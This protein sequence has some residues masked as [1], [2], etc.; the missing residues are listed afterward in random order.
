MK[1]PRDGTP[2]ETPVDRKGFLMTPGKPTEQI[3]LRDNKRI[4]F[5]DQQ[6]KS[7][8]DHGN[9]HEFITTDHTKMLLLTFH[10]RGSE[11]D[12]MPHLF[13]CFV[14]GVYRMQNWKQVVFF[15]EEFNDQSTEEPLRLDLH[16][17][18]S[19]FQVENVYLWFH[20][21]RPPAVLLI[22]PEKQIVY[23]EIKEG[24]KRPR[25]CTS[26]P[27]GSFV[28]SDNDTITT[29]FH[30]LGGP[31]T[32]RT[33]LKRIDATAPVWRASG[34]EVRPCYEY[35]IALISWHIVMVKLDVGR[36]VRIIF[37]S[38]NSAL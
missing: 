26:V 28:C 8:K 36:N 37:S 29:C 18:D 10:F 25:T 2:S 7:T 30:W 21:A 35:P 1:R 14:P 11:D 9:W 27:N 5:E 19:G 17:K 31:T 24:A 12:L 32:Q 13:H 3:T 38:D 15:P 33:V 20:P 22:T 6:K 34:D 4:V 23:H 16:E